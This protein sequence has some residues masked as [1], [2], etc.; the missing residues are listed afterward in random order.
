MKLK[1]TRPL[2]V[3]D[4]ESTGVDREIDKIIDL[5]LRKVSLDGTVTC[6]NYRV[7]PGRPIPAETTAVHGIT[8]E[9]VQGMPTFRDVAQDVLDFIKGC[10]LAGFNSNHFDI[11]MLYNELVR[12]D[13]FLDYR[14]IRMIDVGNIFKIKETRTLSAAVKFYCQREHEGAHGAAADVEATMDVLLAQFEKYDDLPVDMDELALYSN[15]GNKMLDLSGKFSTNKE[16]VVVLNFGK[17]KGMPAKDHLDFLDWM[18]NR[19]NFNRDTV[20]VALEIMGMTDGVDNDD[21]LPY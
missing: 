12:C 20:D 3:L 19:A 16:G 14:S 17:Y 11:P 8:D 10:D 5:S 13:L 2:V 6:I 4:I 21:D 15:Y 9:D 1:L 7:N 18:V